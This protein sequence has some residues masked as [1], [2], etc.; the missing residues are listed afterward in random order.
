[1]NQVTLLDF[2]GTGEQVRMGVLSIYWIG[3][4]VLL[5]LAILGRRRQALM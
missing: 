3:T 4:V 2:M 1:V 5:G